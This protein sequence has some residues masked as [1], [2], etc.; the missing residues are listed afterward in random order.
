VKNKSYKLIVLH[1]WKH[2]KSKWDGFIQY[3]E[4]SDV[5]VFDLP[6]FGKEKLIDNR[7]GIPEYSTWVKK[8]I[9][10]LGE[11]NII[12]LGHSFGGRIAGYIAS[13][14]PV[15]L[16]GL[17]LYGSPLLYRPAPAVRIK[18]KI[19]KLL[20]KLG[21]SKTDG[22]MMY[23]IFKRAVT[24]D[25]TKLLPKI[26]VP[27]LLLW[28]ENDTEVPIA[29]AKEAHAL[30]RGSQLIIMQDAGHNAH[31]DNSNLFYGIIKKFI[32]DL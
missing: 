9:D 8:K 15:W 26:T 11:K 24:F 6:G 25:Q 16:K 5:M 19:A 12:L 14:D 31:L 22:D 28:G 4:P 2:D 10:A 29:I 17:I 30:I 23:P 21:F 27:A 18:I 1:G 20:K 7:W 13:E 3:F 32:D